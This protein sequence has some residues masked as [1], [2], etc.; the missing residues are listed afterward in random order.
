MQAVEESMA[1]FL[2]T[3]FV[4]LCTKKSGEYKTNGMFPVSEDLMVKIE[5]HLK[6]IE[7]EIKKKNWQ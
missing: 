7:K 1:F 4:W 3:K 2:M 6:K 5:P